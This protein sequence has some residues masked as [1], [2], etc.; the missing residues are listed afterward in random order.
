MKRTQRII[1]RPSPKTLR[2]AAIGAWA[3]LLLFTSLTAVA[4]S[5]ANR[6]PSTTNTAQQL[7]I[8]PENPA[9]LS[10]SDRGLYLMA[11]E[12]QSHGDFARADSVMA[13]LS[14]RY[15]VGYVLAERYINGAYKTSNA[16]L[17]QWLAHYQDHPQAAR[18]ASL[19]VR[20]GMDV[21]LPKAEQPLRG[22]G[23]TDHQGRSSMPDSWFTGLGFWRAGQY[24]QAG[25]I[26]SKVSTDESLSD[27]QRAEAYYWSYRA[28]DKLDE[29]SSAHTALTNAARYA[30]TFYGI[31]A[32]AQLGNRLPHAEAPE[33]S[34][35]LRNDPRAIRAALLSQ[36]GDN[37]A[38]EDELRALYSASAK[39]D[40]GGIVTLA[41]ELGL[42]NLQMRLARTPGLSDA[43]QLFAQ[44][45][46]PQY[47]TDLQPIMDSALLMAVARNES[48]FR[49]LA[50]N[51][52]GAL[53]MMQM[54]PATART[55]ERRIGQ[56]LLSTADASANAAP[57]ADRLS[58]PALSAR[59]GA[60]YLKLL[61]EQPA[62]GHN[63]IHLL[64]GYN[65]GPG[66]VVSWKAAAR[67]MNDPL[68]YIESI[69]YAETRNYVM[70]VT[71]QYWI[72][73]RMVDET[74][75]SLRDLAHGQWPELSRNGA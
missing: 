10:A 38:A 33:V 35:A 43:E 70:Q 69:P 39:S 68:L 60:E 9:E 53:G 12:A 51:P 22:E 30:T 59:Y 55:V 29:H 8:A 6:Q 17:T 7:T 74:P 23:Y 28:H 58:N 4:L 54:L 45:P 40:R 1:A 42:P 5:G 32:N 25:V 48:G 31:L 16:E 66:T 41:S 49:E 71:T 72:Y 11:R 64:V 62:I 13:Q 19:A 52:S 21:T 20:R 14:N 61:T 65:A 3:A 2:P 56:Q 46:A 24:A 34:D 37:D 26:F 44:Y 15:L 47:M 57:L 50:R 18:I 67:T 27:W 75:T 36:L 73:Q 63:L